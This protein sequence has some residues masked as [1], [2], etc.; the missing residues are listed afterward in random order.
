A[1]LR[2]ELDAWD[3]SHGKK[4]RLKGF[5]A[6]Y[7]VSFERGAGERMEGQ[8]VEDLAFLLA[9]ILPV[10]V[11][12]LA[13][14][15]ESTG[16]GVRPRGNRIE[17]TVDFTPSPSLMIAASTFITGVI[18]KAMTWRRFDLRALRDRQL[19]VIAG[20]APIPHTSRKGYLARLDC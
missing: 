3:L 6:H 7:N 11:M 10:P 16:V 17:V 18:R 12:L 1:Y 5:S 2:S 8:S 20:Y 9:H 15:R 19:P 4:T 13:T 14:N